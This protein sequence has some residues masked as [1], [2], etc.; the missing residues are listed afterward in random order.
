MSGSWQENVFLD[1]RKVWFTYNRYLGSDVQLRIV[2]S[3][4]ALQSK[5]HPASFT[6]WGM[7]KYDEVWLVSLVQLIE[8]TMSWSNYS[9]LVPPGCE[10]NVMWGGLCV[11]MPAVKSIQCIHSNVQQVP[12]QLRILEFNLS[13][14]T[15]W[16]PDRNS[17]SSLVFMLY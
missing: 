16:H 11:R 4:R 8:K 14:P 15:I 5:Q 2:I 7:N 6:Y 9:D 10:W 13:P 17:M 1:V 12:V 3:A